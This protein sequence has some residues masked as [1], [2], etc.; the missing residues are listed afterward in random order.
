MMLA[1]MG[2]E[3]VRVERSADSKRNPRKDCELRGKFSIALD[4]KQK[5]GVE[6]LLRLITG[7]DALIEG[8]RPGVMEKLGLGPEICLARNPRLVFGRVTGWGQTGPLCQAAGHDINYIALTGALHAVGRKGEKPVPPVNLVG[9]FGGG[10]MLLAFGIVCALLEAKKS[11]RGQ[12]V[13]AAMTDGSALLLAFVNSMHAAGHWEPERGVNMIDTGSHFYEVYE[14]RD[15]KYVCIGSFE[16]QFYSLLIEKAN[17][18][19]ELF[20]D[21]MNK[22]RWTEMKEGL[23]AVFKTK[24][25]DEWCQIME[26]TD[27]CFAPVLNFVEAQRHPHNVARQTYV[28]VDGML[29]PAPAPRF[30]RTP[31]KVRFGPRPIGEDTLDVL[32]RWNEA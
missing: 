25:R 8:Y 31:G 17:L 30:S 22:S 7:A 3:V 10:G 16:P 6:T 14:T 27:V 1:D 29:Q 13:D 21:Q 19:R 2:A 5:D 12:V 4:L 9:D 26:G 32:R 15:G 24:T 23:A 28:D 18:D 11:G 20:S